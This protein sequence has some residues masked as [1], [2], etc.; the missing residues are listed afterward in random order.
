MQTPVALIHEQMTFEQVQAKV[1]FDEAAAAVE[2]LHQA[3]FGMT[4]QPR[5]V[6]PET[7]SEAV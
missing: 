4:V 1:A 3:L 7:P 6:V 2:A 5:Y